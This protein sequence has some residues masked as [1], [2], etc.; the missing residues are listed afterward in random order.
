MLLHPWLPLTSVKLLETL[1]AP[2]LSLSGARLGA[3]RLG[4][5]ARLDPLFPK[6]Q[7]PAAAA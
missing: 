6:Q 3:G 5:V 4:T 7:P 2:D 1:G